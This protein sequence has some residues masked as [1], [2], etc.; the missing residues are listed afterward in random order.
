[1]MESSSL[2]N[3]SILR[4]KSDV[5]ADLETHAWEPPKLSK[6]NSLKLQKLSPC[7]FTIEGRLGSG[8]FG[9]VFLSRDGKTNE[10]VALKKIPKHSSHFNR[11]SLSREIQAGNRLSHSGIVQFKNFFETENSF[12]LI[13][14][15]LHGVDLYTLMRQRNFIPL[16][17]PEAICL[18]RQ[19]ITAL[20]YCHTQNTCHRDV[21]WENVFLTEEGTVKL[22]DFGLSAHISP[23]DLCQD[24]VGSPYFA[25]P[26]IVA[27][28]CYSGFKADVYSCGMVLYGLLYGRLDVQR[29]DIGTIQ[30]PDR[31]QSDF[32]FFISRSAKDFLSAMLD[33]DPVD[34]ISMEQALKH[35][36]LEER[37]VD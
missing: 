23:H 15:L 17:E 25:A 35:R 4:N 22:I 31:C 13:Y 19:L 9:E 28:E 30:W 26:E 24:F 16:K 27:R 6:G 8:A 21:K 11:R 14:E 18:M 37:K 29:S 12:Y 33:E 10:A 34:R 36:W 2:R 32:P 7:D 1:M 5:S 20:V 3:C